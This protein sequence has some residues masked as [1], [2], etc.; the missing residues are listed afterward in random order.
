MHI[1]AHILFMNIFSIIINLIIV[2][3]RISYIIWYIL[4]YKKYI[5]S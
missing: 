2:N 5:K 4:I 3:K 1:Y